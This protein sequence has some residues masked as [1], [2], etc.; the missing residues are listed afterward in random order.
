MS[1]LCSVLVPMLA[2]LGCAKGIPLPDATPK[3]TIPA[4][5]YVIG[6][7]TDA[8]N[9]SQNTP[10]GSA[11]PAHPI[12]LSRPFQIDVHEVTV[13]Q[14]AACAALGKCCDEN[15]GDYVNQGNLPAEV[16]IEEARQYC[17][18]RNL[19][20]PT[21]V[22]WEVAARVKDGQGHIQVYPWGDVARACGDVPSQDCGPSNKSL[23][24]VASNP[25][26]CTPLGVYDMAGSVPEWVEDDFTFSSGCRYETPVGVLCSNDSGCMTSQC[27]GGNTCQGE[28]IGTSN[29][30]Y[31]CPIDASNPPTCLATPVDEAVIDPLHVTYDHAAQDQGTDCQGSSVGTGGAS[32]RNPLLKGGGVFESQCRQNPA[33]RFWA[34]DGMSINSSGDSRARGGFR[35]ATG[36]APQA[37]LTA[38][39]QLVGSVQP[40]CGVLSV[41]LDGTTQPAGWGTRIQVVFASNYGVAPATFDATT[42]RYT[43]DLTDTRVLPT[44]P[45]ASSSQFL[46]YGGAGLVLTNLPVGR[47]NVRI[48]YPGQ[49]SGQYSGPDGGG[50]CTVS[51]AQTVDMSSGETPCTTN[52]TGTSGNPQCL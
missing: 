46:I 31:Q 47:F 13:E 9:S 5:S 27:A 43:L 48:Q 34:L 3:V 21:E 33:A 10:C 11:E 24:P 23:Q 8:C 4:G 7:T 2:C 14:Y 37:T 49:N 6:G 36:N 45:C 50:N 16:N 32:S 26:D 19:R 15:V 42:S 38:R 20:L 25:I 40:S 51:Y 29:N 41:S 28:C 22:E 1:R 18:Y 17:R 39:L 30:M 44:T 35:C 52:F 12:A